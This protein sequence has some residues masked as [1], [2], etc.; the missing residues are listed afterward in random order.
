MSLLIQ[1]KYLQEQALPIF[2][3][4]TDERIDQLQHEA[5]EQAE[6]VPEAERAAYRRLVRNEI[7]RIRKVI[8]EMR[9]DGIKAHGI[10]AAL[11]DLVWKFDQS[12]NRFLEGNSEFERNSR[13]VCG[14]NR[15]IRDKI[16]QC[17][18]HFGTIERHPIGEEDPMLSWMDAMPAKADESL[19][20]SFQG[21]LRDRA[22]E[23][24]VTAKVAK[25]TLD[26]LGYVVK[27]T[28]AIAFGCRGEGEESCKVVLGYLEAG[29]KKVQE[30]AEDVADRMGATPVLKRMASGNAVTQRLV[31]LGLDR[32]RSDAWF[33]VS[34]QGYVQDCTALSLHAATAA[35][36]MGAASL[37]RLSAQGLQTTAQT[38]SRIPGAL[39]RDLEQVHLNL[40]TAAAPSRLSN[41]QQTPGFQA[42]L[43]AESDVQ[44]HSTTPYRQF[45]KNGKSIAP[46]PYAE[47]PRHADVYFHAT[48]IEN[49][50][51][52]LSS[53]SIQ[54]LDLTAFRG[55]FVSTL[56]E[57]QYGDI[58]FALNR[59]IEQAGPALHAKFR[60]GSHNV[61]FAQS[62]PVTL[63]TLEYV[64]V[65]SDVLAAH[66]I[67]ALGKELSLAA[68]REIPVVPLEPIIKL[69]KGRLKREGVY[70]P[71]EWPMRLDI[72]AK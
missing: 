14:R 57:R 11:S 9:D 1:P 51:K 56:P 36:S 72:W 32:E 18:P 13:E 12:R 17:T 62:I 39:K 24:V 23:H 64:A 15:D 25:A 34:A 16:G 71:E 31:E 70:V 42:Y 2:L 48:S 22:V 38:V 43:R 65:K 46:I 27:E 61:G 55:A 3:P 10:N 28:A 21:F 44:F 53:K 30:V 66:T 68:G 6:Q 69:A 26:T 58:V 40:E 29:A 49:A 37:V 8:V 63:E 7:A 67:E 5:D 4:S 19:V 50:L 47:V 59:R 33:H 52:I 20:G 41:F 35:G 45:T 54:R 60:A